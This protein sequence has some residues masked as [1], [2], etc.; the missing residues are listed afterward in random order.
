[1]KIHFSNLFNDDDKKL[2]E[3]DKNFL[4]KF[5][6]PVLKDLKKNREKTEEKIVTMKKAK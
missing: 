1:M 6:D 4:F 3:D 2:Q 5:L